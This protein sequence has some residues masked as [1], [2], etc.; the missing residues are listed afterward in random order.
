MCVCVCVCVSLVMRMRNK[1][2]PHLQDEHAYEQ[3]CFILTSV[4]VS[5]ELLLY[6]LCEKHEGS[7]S[8]KAHR[9][10][11]QNRFI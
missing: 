11:Q 9:M 8:E 7:L 10:P 3:W 5:L 4:E 1:K 2:G 6:L